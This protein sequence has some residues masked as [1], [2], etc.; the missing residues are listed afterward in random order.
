LTHS[1]QFTPQLMQGTRAISFQNCGR[2]FSLLN[3]NNADTVS[4]RTQNWLDADG[5][6][7][8]RGVGTFMVSGYASAAKWWVVDDNGTL[9]F[10]CCLLVPAIH[11]KHAVHMLLPVGYDPQGPLRFVDIQ[12]KA[13]GPL[14][15]LG[16]VRLSW[17][18]ALHNQVGKSICGN[19]NIDPCPI[20]GFVRHAGKRF[21]T[22]F[23]E[24][25]LAITANGQIVGP[26]NGYAWIVEL[27]RGAPR[28]LRIDYVEVLPETPLLICIAYPVGTTINITA[29]AASWC[30][31]GSKDFTCAEAFTKAASLQ[32]VR[33]GPGN[34]YHMDS[35]GVLTFR[36]VQPPAG[37]V[38]R[39]NWFIPSRTDPYLSEKAFA[40]GRLERSGVYL[41]IKAYEPY[42]QVDA[43]CGGS[44]PYCP[45][46]PAVFDP[47]VCPNGYI[48]KAYDSCCSAANLSRC[49][50]AGQG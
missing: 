33:T 41:P 30:W 49:V 8:G 34:Q 6:A 37:Y 2:R 18:A 3:W 45:G 21:S 25:G 14:R 47:D 31:K 11:A 13:G 36:V 35:S 39:P 16:H 27:T 43:T 29:H 24:T 32:E 7:S 5:S 44:D 9:C 46:T 42:L 1:D 50:Y 28:N 12:S 15:G 48:Q 23:N 26:V 4:G 19:G 10:V 20:L 22:G 40:I 17:D 38:G